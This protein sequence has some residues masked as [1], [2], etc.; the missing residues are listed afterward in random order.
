M[1]S[2]L[3][4]G[5]DPV[6]PLVRLF[7]AVLLQGQVKNF[8]GMI[9]LI[10]RLRVVLCLARCNDVFGYLFY[11]FVFLAQKVLGWNEGSWLLGCSCDS[12][13]GLSLLSWCPVRAT[14][15]LFEV[16]TAIRFLPEFTG[17]A[18]LSTVVDPLIHAL[19][20]IEPFVMFVSDLTFSVGFAEGLAMIVRSIDRRAHH[21]LVWMSLNVGR[22]LREGPPAALAAAEAP[23][24]PLRVVDSPQPLPEWSDDGAW[25]LFDG[26][27]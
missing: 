6:W 24:P 21:K 18:C 2:L 9:V 12:S 17:L 3:P 22:M 4:F 11:P 5:N 10:A 19:R 8:L 7:V 14:E 15:C 1:M 26:A 25:N 27:E 20:Y 23:P 16:F 13:K